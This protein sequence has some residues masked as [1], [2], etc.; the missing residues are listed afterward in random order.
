MGAY[1]LAEIA[2]DLIQTQ[3]KS[4]IA[5]ALA[6]VRAERNDPVV[7]T[8]VPKEYFQYATAHVYR[9]PAVFTII[10]SMDI[11]NETMGAN[12]INAMDSI[13]VAVV[14]EDRLERLVVKK[15]WRYQCALMEILHESVLTS[16]DNAVRLF[17]RVKTCEF[18]GIVNLTSKDKPDACFRKEVSLRLQVE[19]IENLE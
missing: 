4:N 3:I 9:P 10:D 12:H 8:E 16:S 18:S 13:I 6:A 7:T 14:V 19:H 17:S 1:R 2:V 15:A 11:R 5:A